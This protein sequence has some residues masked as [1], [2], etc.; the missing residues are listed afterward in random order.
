MTKKERQKRRDKANG[1]VYE[2]KRREPIP[3]PKIIPLKHKQKKIK[4]I[5]KAEIPYL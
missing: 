2:P 4:E 3:A 5:I 1:L